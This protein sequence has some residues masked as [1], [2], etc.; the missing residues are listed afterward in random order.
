MA[1]PEGRTVSIA[2]ASVV[3]TRF[4][5]R[6]DTVLSEISSSTR[7]HPIVKERAAREATRRKGDVRQTTGILSAHQEGKGFQRK[8]WGSEP[9][10]WA[11][12]LAEVKNSVIAPTQDMEKQRFEQKHSLIDPRTSKWLV[13]W[14]VLKLVVLVYVS[15][16]TPFEVSFIPIGKVGHFNAL[17]PA[18]SEL[19]VLFAINRVVD[20][21]FTIDIVV[22][23]VT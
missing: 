19:T 14:D 3:G 9:P 6:N 8:E 7:R 18:H 21:V 16:V 4:S 15:L 23:F 2:G 1:P 13:K 12:K 20:L 5:H 10:K 22:Q 11:L 17:D